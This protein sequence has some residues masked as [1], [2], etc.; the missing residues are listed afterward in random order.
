MMIA[1]S[2]AGALSM[3]AN[4]KMWSACLGGMSEKEE[5]GG[6]PF[7]PREFFLLSHQ[8]LVLFYQQ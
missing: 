5:E 6:F 7:E 1:A 4:L 3:Q 2:L 8:E